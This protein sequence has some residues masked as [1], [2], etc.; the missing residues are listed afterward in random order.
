MSATPTFDRQKDRKEK[1]LLI[2]LL[3]KN[4]AGDPMIIWNSGLQEV[5]VKNSF[6]LTGKYW[7]RSN[8]KKPLVLFVLFG[9]CDFKIIFIL[10]VNPE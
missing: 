9:L 2:D 7:F 3:K 5:Y 6:K 1:H 4:W 10:H 8:I